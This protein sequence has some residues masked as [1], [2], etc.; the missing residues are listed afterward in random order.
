MLK[1][2]NGQ[3][4]LDKKN[5]NKKNQKIS[6]NGIF[7]YPDNFYKEDLSSTLHSKYSYK[8]AQELVNL[9]VNVSFAGRIMSR[10]IMGKASFAHIQDYEGQIQI[11]V[12]QNNISDSLYNDHFKSWNIGDI[13]GVKG[14]LFKTKRGE[15]TINCYE[16]LLLSKVLKSFPDKFHGLVNKEIRYRK[17]YLDLISN[18]RTRKTFLTRSKI[19]SCIRDFMIKKNFLEV[20]TPM[21]QNIPG[22]ALA[23]PFITHHNSLN[24]KMYLRISPE[25]YLKRLIVG[26]F[27][28]IFEINKNFRNEGLSSYHNPEFTMM[29][30]YMAYSNYKDL[31][32]LIKEL[33]CDV[34][35]KIFG[36]PIIKCGCQELDFSKSFFS[37]TMIESIL[38]YIPNINSND[39]KSLPRL[40][41]IAQKLDIKIE[42]KWGIGKIQFEIFE[43]IVP[44][45]LIQPTFITEYPI[46]VSP[47]ARSND[48]N[49]SITDRFELYING[50]EIGNGFSELSDPI[51][52][53]N[54]FLNQIQNKDIKKSSVNFFD[55]DY[56]TALKYG[57]PPT[58]GLGIGID[59]V[60]MLLTNHDN[61]KDVILFPTF[62]KDT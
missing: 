38:K 39:L 37:M 14:I 31:M 36:S 53:K 51:E 7:L 9:N 28:K 8:T 44:K 18:S 49:S 55:K 26:G 62:K 52:Q 20:E 19:I 35:N 23:K 30:L 27:E 15:L 56:I 47:L 40:K 13:I 24:M 6:K 42:K 46:E 58:A 45:N 21:M 60:V 17:R 16:V 34:T 50:C 29:E 54:R 57:L 1:K 5:K 22:G 59:R 3:Q 2:K 10:R 11:Y 41:K 33:F 4:I 43:K 12:T 61:I 32:I 48:L 25:L